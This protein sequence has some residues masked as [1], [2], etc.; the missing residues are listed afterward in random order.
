MARDLAYI[1]G[2]HFYTFPPLT[3]DSTSNTNLTQKLRCKRKLPRMNLRA[4]Q[5]SLVYFNHS[6]ETEKQASSS[7]L[8]LESGPISCHSLPCL[9]L[10]CSHPS[11][12]TCP[13]LCWESWGHRVWMWLLAEIS[14]PWYLLRKY[15]PTN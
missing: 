6:A 14:A 3:T 10:T 11:S 5:T 15:V 7:G 12:T 4:L 2:S 1:E 13:F 8:C 9:G